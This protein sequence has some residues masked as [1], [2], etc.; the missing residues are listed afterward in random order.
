MP[1]V[2]QS[3]RPPLSREFL[4]HESLLLLSQ[5]HEK[6]DHD[7]SHVVMQHTIQSFECRHLW[8]D[9]S[10]SSSDLEIASPSAKHQYSGQT[11]YVC[12]RKHRLRETKLLDAPKSLKFP[13]VN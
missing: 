5:R 13:S 10:P 4:I 3:L 2:H 1:C 11:D 7:L 9:F 12:A 8:P 6:T